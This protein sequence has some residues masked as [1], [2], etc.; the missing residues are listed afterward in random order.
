MDGQ[1][2]GGPDSLGPILL[3]AGFLGVLLYL[4]GLLVW[5]AG[6]ISGVLVGHGWPESSPGDAFSIALN[7]LQQPGQPAQAWPDAA[8]A[9]IGPT[10]LVYVLLGLELLPAGWLAW[11]TVLFGLNWRRRREFRFFRLGFASSSEVKKMLSAD[12]VLRKAGSVRPS[13]KGKSNVQPGDVGFYLGRDI[14]SRL[15]LYA[16]IEDVFIVLAP[17]RQG[18]D[19]HFCTPYTIDAPG[20]C[21][22]TSTRADAFTNT[23]AMRAKRGKIFVFDP[24]KMT[25]WPERLR[26]SPVRGCDDPIIAANRALAIIHGSGLELAGDAAYFVIGA[27]TV[28]RCYLHAAAISGGT[29]R[30]V[31][32]WCVQQTNPEPVNILRKGERDGRSAPG[33][34]GALEASVSADRH[35]RAV[36]FACAVQALGCFADPGV[37][38]ACSPGPDEIFDLEDFLSGPNTLYIL[39]K[40]QK[41]GSVAPVVTAMMEDLFDQ[42][43]KLASMMPGSR[44][45]PPLTVELNEAAHI[46]PMPHLPGYMGDS[47]GFSI[48][49][50]VYL[51]SLSQARAKW[52]DH[53][54]MIMWD[55]AA[56]R[57][58]MGGAGNIADL[59]D[60]S[61]LMGETRAREYR[62]TRGPAGTSVQVGK[63]WRPVLSAEEVRT[64]EFGKAVVVARAARPVEVKLTPWW[65][66]KDG[67]EIAAG[68][69]D[70]EAKVL[71]YTKA[72]RA[73]QKAGATTPGT[74]VQP[75]AAAGYTGYGYGDVGAAAP[76]W[77]DS[78]DTPPGI[79]RAGHPQLT[80]PPPAVGLPVGPPLGLPPV[81]MSATGNGID[82]AVTHIPTRS[83]GLPSLPDWTIELEED[84]EDR[85][86]R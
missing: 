24:N 22:V 13:T 71:E 34:A 66:R 38:D 18:K 2:T 16:S 64:L 29:M 15:P 23:Y 35:H 49:L 4:V 61:R 30:E 17:P 36:M 33:W 68:K 58:I 62:T 27:A 7:L 1:R 37:M 31:N 80:G 54:A 8:V 82:S 32:R 74:E 77:P 60:I 84:D 42:T 12:A 86:P 50:H 63:E 67:D 19:V 5:L 78:P 76:T 83:L 51:Q 40:E 9:A 65:E 81:P 55:N 21:I 73:R 41:N 44:L 57:I 25:H 52:G 70:T 47:G 39:G 75:Q 59:E 56:V 10:W 20:P 14:R 72:F 46:A 43:R 85:G 48:A 45:D 28:L 11:R 53:E 79:D 69:A 3:G 6:Q 26:W